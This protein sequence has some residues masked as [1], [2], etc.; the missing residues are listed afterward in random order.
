MDKK[1]ALITLTFQWVLMTAKIADMIDIYISDTLGRMI[2]LKQVGLY[3]NDG[4]IFIPDSMAQKLQ[5]YIRN[6]KTLQVTRI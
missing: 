6:Y 4:L 2:E 3:R 1:I 5:K